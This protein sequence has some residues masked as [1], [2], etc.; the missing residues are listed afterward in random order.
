[1]EYHKCAEHVNNLCI[2]ILTK[3]NMKVQVLE[4]YHLQLLSLLA[5]DT[6][7][8][9]K[10]KLIFRNRINLTYAHIDTMGITREFKVT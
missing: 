5:S 7:G 6:A 1:M 10:V 8:A 9:H 4:T 3:G 2:A